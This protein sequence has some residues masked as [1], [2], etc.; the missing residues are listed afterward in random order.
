[1]TPAEH[2]IPA[3]IRNE[4]FYAAARLCM[5]GVAVVG[6]PVA[7]FFLSRVVTTADEIRAQVQQQNI[8]LILLT[9]EVKFR[10]ANVD[11]HEQRLRRLELADKLKN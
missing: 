5:I 8:A 6:M 3:I 2:K 11:D 1:M 9:S 10:F 4:F 7:T